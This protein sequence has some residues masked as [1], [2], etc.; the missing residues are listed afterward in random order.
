MLDLEKELLENKWIEQ[1]QLD[2]ARL[3]A[4]TSK[5]SI[6]ICLVKLGFLSEE[7]LACFFAQMGG[8]AFVRISDYAISPHVLHLLE[9]NYC[10][11]NKVFPL[12]KVGN[13]LFLACANPLN[14]ALID[15]VSKITGLTIEPVVATT[16]EILA[17]IDLYYKLDEQNFEITRYL[18]KHN[19]LSGVS[20]WREADRLPV[21]GKI[22]LT[23]VDEEVKLFAPRVIEGKVLNVSADCSA[24]GAEMPLFLPPHI[25]VSFTLYGFEK[26]G[27]ETCVIEAKGEILRSTMV[28]YK[29]Y[30]LGIR[31]N[32][33]TAEDRK[34]LVRLFSN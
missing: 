30:L 22:Q 3:E 23:L 14:A 34:L 5:K 8:F 21:S 18:I 6:W 2:V 20:Q 28:N 4:T 33:L 29:N 13:T 12:Y 26:C 11:Q 19:P 7:Q 17:A 15:D 10:L 24:L 25:Y 1:W 9:E 32:N 27:F 16:H 31:I